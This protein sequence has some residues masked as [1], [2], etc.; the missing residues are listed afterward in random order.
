MTFSRI[1]HLAELKRMY[2]AVLKSYGACCPVCERW[3]K[4]YK[5]PLN[6]T[7]VRTLMWLWH[8]SDHGRRWVDVPHEARK[9]QGTYDHTKQYSTLKHWGFL[10]HKENSDNPLTKES[11]V[12]KPTYKAGAFLRGE[13]VVEK[14]ALTYNDKSYG[15]D[16]DLVTPSDILKGFN[17]PRLMAE[18]S[19]VTDK[20]TL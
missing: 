1:R 20:L 5:R 13:L 17:Y 18:Q 14:Y 4:V 10:D 19:V 7:M 6:A 12:W 9:A 8:L 3:G 11:G 2:H 15:M 16:G